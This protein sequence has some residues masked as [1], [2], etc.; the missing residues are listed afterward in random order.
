M[1]VMGPTKNPYGE[2]HIIEKCPHCQG[3]LTGQDIPDDD[4]PRNMRVEN[5][6]NDRICMRVFC[7]HC[8]TTWI[9]FY[10]YISMAQPITGLGDFVYE[11]V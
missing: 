3:A 8:F 9:E 2:E 1:R 10:K 5:I 6:V 7:P 11:E 4:H